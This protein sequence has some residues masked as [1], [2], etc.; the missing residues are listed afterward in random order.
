MAGYCRD[1]SYSRWDGGEGKYFC[2]EHYKFVDEYDTCYSHP[3]NYKSDYDDDDSYDN[4]GDDGD[5]SL[6][7]IT[8]AC[9]NIFRLDDDNYYLTTLRAFRNNIMKKNE[10]YHK[11][12]VLYDI[13]GPVISKCLIK[14]KD[15]TNVAMEVMIQVNNA[16]NAINNNEYDKAVD[17]YYNMTKNL[18]FRYGITIPDISDEMVSNVSIENSGTGKLVLKK[19]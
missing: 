6:C 7:Y 19:M 3:D 18:A 13:V 12:L 9:C 1:C 4:G 8:T 10:K 15:K 2:S 16:C 17:I 11:M 5:V 14:D